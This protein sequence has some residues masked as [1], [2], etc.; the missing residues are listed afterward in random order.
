MSDTYPIRVHWTRARDEDKAAAILSALEL[1]WAVQVESL[2]FN[3]PVLPDGEDGDEMDLYL[4][5]V[6]F[7]QA[8]ATVDSNSDVV[9]GDGYNG[10]AAYMVVDHNLP[11]DWVDSFVA[12]EF[13]HVL[14]YATDYNELT[15]PLWEAVATAAQ[16][17]TLGE[18]GDWDY[19]V[20]S[21][22]EIPW[23]PTLTGDSYVLGPR[24]GLGTTFEY[25]AA[26]WVMHLDRYY[27][28]GDGLMGS[29]LWHATANEGTENEPD[30]VDAIEAVAGVDIAAFLNSLAVARWL[31]G[32]RWDDRG[33]S[34]AEDWARLRQVPTDT[35]VTDRSIPAT[36]RFARQPNVYGQSFV[37]IQLQDSEEGPLTLDVSSYSGLQ[38]SIIAMVTDDVGVWQS[39]SWG[40]NPSLELNLTGEAEVVV[41]ITNLGAEGFDG[42][43]WPYTAGDLALQVDL[44]NRQVDI[45]DTGDPGIDPVTDEDPGAVCACDAGTTSGWFAFPLWMMWARRRR[46]APICG[47]ESPNPLHAPGSGYLDHDSQ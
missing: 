14:Q 22:Q 10:A 18:V 33:L 8:Y 32:D 6:G 9:P 28:A 39:E 24:D 45:A 2:G 38:S 19:D 47:Q 21:F 31:T 37:L 11:D 36:V 35:L 5:D 42:D 26:L 30:V 15:L 20:S 27:G 3:Q 29:A 23:A 34:E 7:G 16:T 25:G 17:W 40:A 43:D 13:N 44:A 1:S 12:H 41:A 46:Y 4:S